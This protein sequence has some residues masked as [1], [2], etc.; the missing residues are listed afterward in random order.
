M[1]RRCALLA[2]ALAAGAGFA[3][4]QTPPPAIA[5]E[6][7]TITHPPLGT[8]SSS[9]L[10]APSSQLQL[11]TAQKTT[12]VNAIRRDSAKAGSPISFA[13]TIGAPVPPSIELYG[14]PDAA[15]ADVPEAKLVKYTKVQN[16]VVLVDPT[17][18]RVVDVI[19]GP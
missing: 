7:D 15:L 4:A 16:Q 17:T 19:A 14:L 3:A 6:P 18:M 10:G 8:P 2:L 1:T 13:T 9:P 11:T 12:I 5:P